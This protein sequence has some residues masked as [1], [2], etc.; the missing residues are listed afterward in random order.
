MASVLIRRLRSPWMCRRVRRIEV[1]FDELAELTGQR[2]A[3]DGR[4]VDIVAEMDRDELIGNTGCRSVAAL[5]AW[6]TGVSPSNAATI[7]TIAQRVEEFPAVRRRLREG[8]LSLDQVGVIAERAGAGSDAHY[9]G[10]GRGGHGHP[11]ADGGEAG[12]APGPRAAPGPQAR[13]SPRRPPDEKYTTYRITL[14]TWK[15]RSSTPPWHRTATRRSRTGNATATPA[16]ARRHVTP[17]PTPM[18]RVPRMR[19]AARCRPRWTR[20]WVW[21]RPAGTPR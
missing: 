10:V 21:S 6:R 20:S 18:R 5:V 13:R 15:R 12:T 8:R 3:I 16:T 9:A 17:T 11:V 4:I 14:P 2:N 7:A 19:A 1:L